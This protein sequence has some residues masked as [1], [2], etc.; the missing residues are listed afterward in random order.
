VVW[1]SIVTAAGRFAVEPGAILA[2]RYEILEYVGKGA[3]GVVYKA[4]DRALDEIVAIKTLSQQALHDQSMTHRFLAEIKLA[5]RVSHRNVCRIHDYGESESVRFI[6][7]QFVDGVELRHMIRRQGGL[8]HDEG[9]DIAL[10]LVDGLEAIHEQ[11][12]VHRDLKTA[13][14]MVDRRGTALLM[15]FGIAKLWE[16]QAGATLTASGQ[17]VG[18]PQYMSPEQA[19]GQP[20]D[21]RSDIYALGVVLIE[22]FTGAPPFPADSFAAMLYKKMHD[23]LPL[24]SPAVAGLPA[25]LVPIVRKALAPAAADRYG[26]TR[27][28]RTALLEARRPSSGDAPDA[29]STIAAKVQHLQSAAAASAAVPDRVGSRGRRQWLVSGVTLAAIVAISVTIRTVLPFFGSTAF[30]ARPADLST[31]TPPTTTP[32]G[33]DSSR[34]GSSAAVPLAETARS[35]ASSS[36][37]SPAVSNSPPSNRPVDACDNENVAGCMA[38]AQAAAA[39]NDAERAAALYLKACS[40]EAAAACTELGVLYNRGL[41][42][43]RDVTQAALYYERGCTQGDMAGCNNLGTVYQFG[44]LGFRD[45][46]KAAALYERA[47]S[48]GQMDACA[49]LGR[50]LLDTPGAASDQRERGRALLVK[51]CAAGIARACAT[52]Q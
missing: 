41:G 42:V 28:L 7:M 5:R 43:A 50:L 9:F 38:L 29:T 16:G 19:Q 47:C 27:E 52:P 30:D 39:A 20:L 25:A 10:Q 21:P 32:P 40:G 36:Q 46:T 37:H 3:M 34:S 33:R 8:S 51:A 14:V 15:D 6:S 18:T 1:R 2:N 49:N 13:N 48:N 22:V 12:I 35:D 24:D 31:T 11:G 4:H 26:S 45:P 23:P 17:I 44:S